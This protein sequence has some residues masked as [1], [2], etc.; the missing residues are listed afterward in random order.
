MKRW[1]ALSAVLVIAAYSTPSLSQVRPSVV[2]PVAAAAR[3]PAAHATTAPPIKVACIGNSIT[4]GYGQP[5]ADW[6]TKS[7]PA[8]LGQKLG[9]A[10]IVKNFGV[11][12]TTLL[13]NGN[14]PY[15]NRSE[16]AASAAWKPDIVVIALGTNDAKTVN[17]AHYGD[18]LADYVAMIQYYDTLSSHPR[19]F[20]SLP[21]TLYVDSVAKPI[22]PT[23]QHLATYLL[24]KI[25]AAAVQ[26]HAVVIDVHA[27]T[28]GHAAMFADGVHPN[29]AGANIIAQTVYA[30]IHAAQLVYVRDHAVPV[31]GRP[32]G[33]R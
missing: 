27:A 20:V 7:Y 16:L 21:P 24:P 26:R 33:L 9:A 23:E 6:P 4:V 13:K 14:M 29:A 8:V 17:V 11:S 28:A 15:W 1:S 5:P 18:F 22:Y 32:P 31:G 2:R 10:Y 30:A 12:G 19:V 25:R 3:I